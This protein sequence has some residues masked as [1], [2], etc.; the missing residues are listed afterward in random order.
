MKN[1]IL[2]RVSIRAS[3]KSRKQKAGE[4]GF[5]SGTRGPSNCAISQICSLV[6]KKKKKRRQKKRREREREREKKVRS[7]EFTCYRRGQVA[8]HF[9]LFS[10]PVFRV[11][12]PA[13]LTDLIREIGPVTTLVLTSHHKGRSKFIEWTVMAVH[14]PTAIWPHGSEF[15]RFI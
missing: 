15:T 10:R 6:R 13:C 1:P 2:P 8:Q 7:R 11:I 12:W 14:F 3:P 4:K 9:R 5:D